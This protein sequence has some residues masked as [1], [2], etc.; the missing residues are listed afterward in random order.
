MHETQAQFAGFRVV[1]RYRSVIVLIIAMVEN[2]VSVCCIVPCVG[3][4]DL[5]EHFT[6]NKSL[7]MSFQTHTHFFLLYVSFMQISVYFPITAASWKHVLCKQNPRN[8]KTNAQPEKNVN[9]HSLVRIKMTT[10]PSR[11]DRGQI[12]HRL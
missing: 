7:T 12:K 1:D 6:Q 11:W 5:K 3:L 10:E 9:T 4:K 2:S 8:H